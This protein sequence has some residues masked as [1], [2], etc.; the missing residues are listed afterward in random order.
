MQDQQH[1][2]TGSACT[3]PIARTV[4]D[5][6]AQGAVKA[7]VEISIIAERG[8]KQP[9]DLTDPAW[10]HGSTDTEIVTVVKKGIPLAM[11]PGY[12]GRLSDVEIRNVVAY[13]RSL[14]SSQA[15]TTAA[16]PAPQSTERTLEVADYVELPVTGDKI[17]QSHFGA[18]GARQHPS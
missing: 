6:R 14:S 5:A 15:A 17:D 3:T 13:V 1:W 10:D 4:T 2:L 9:P 11:M 16:A 7:G 12:E 18:A 8:G